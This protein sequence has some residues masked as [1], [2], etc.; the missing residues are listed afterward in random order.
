M[1]SCVR[2]L[3]VAHLMAPQSPS[4]SGPLRHGTHT[5]D[6]AFESLEQAANMHVSM[7]R[8]TLASL[9]GPIFGENDL[10]RLPDAWCDPHACAQPRRT[11]NTNPYRVSAVC[12]NVLLVLI[13]SLHQVA[14]N[15]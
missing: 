13:L 12:I 1:C 10:M 4:G 15:Q 5:L 2:V 8:E 3:A 7:Q 14:S 6:H 9:S 11:S